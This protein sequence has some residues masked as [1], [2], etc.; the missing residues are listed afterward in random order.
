MQRDK[1]LGFKS[2]CLGFSVKTY[3]QDLGVQG[4]ELGFISLQFT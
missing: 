4:L 1:W 2:L 3:A